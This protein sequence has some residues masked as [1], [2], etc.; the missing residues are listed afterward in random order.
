[1][2]SHSF[3]DREEARRES[4]AMPRPEEMSVGVNPDLLCRQAIGSG[5]DDVVDTSDVPV[6]EFVLPKRSCAPRALVVRRADDAAWKPDGS[7]ICVGTDC[8]VD[9]VPV[10][11]DT[12]KHAGCRLRVQR[13]LLRHHK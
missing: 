12:S 11:A 6:E 2:D 13:C 8:R 4:C 1:M 5:L 3:P 7:Y 10:G 9:P